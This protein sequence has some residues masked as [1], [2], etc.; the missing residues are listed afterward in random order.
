MIRI[1]QALWISLFAITTTLSVM[2]QDS[3]PW[4]TDLSQARR[5][6][7]QQQRLVLLHFWGDGCPPCQHL[8]TSVFNQPELIRVI[9]T[10]FV[11]VKIHVQQQPNIASF[12]KIDKI[13]TDIV[14]LPSGVQV[15]RTTSPGNVNTYIAM[16]D[17]GRANALAKGY[18]EVE[19]VAQNVDQAAQNVAQNVDRVAQ[20]VDRAAQ[21]FAQQVPPM[22]SN[23][24]GSAGDVAVNGQSILPTWRNAPGSPPGS[25]ATEGAPR[26][27]VVNEF[28][29]P[30]DRN[31]QADPAPA[32]PTGPR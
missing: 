8:E 17:Q 9:M 13:P 2:A 29:G 14:V 21:H 32:A 3:I 18:Q 5:I 25:A 26:G 6:A 12:Y 10:H 19:R 31:T 27:T 11:P 30:L 7:E 4:I 23:L 1:Q 24:A 22:M 20:H 28:V 15:F 16:L